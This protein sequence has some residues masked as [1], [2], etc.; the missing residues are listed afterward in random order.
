MVAQIPGTAGGS[1]GFT[2]DS[3]SQQEAGAGRR[4]F[5]MA[6]AAGGV[7]LVARLEFFGKSLHGSSS[8]RNGDPN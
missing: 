5:S 2:P 1:G 8:V 7:C 6:M 4:V 3:F